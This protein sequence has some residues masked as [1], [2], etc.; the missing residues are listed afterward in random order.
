MSYSWDPRTQ[1]DPSECTATLGGLRTCAAWKQLPATAPS[2]RPLHFNWEQGR[3]LSAY[4]LV[5]VTGR[6]AC[7][8]SCCRPLS[9]AMHWHNNVRLMFRPC[10]PPMQAVR[11]TAFGTRLFW[12]LSVTRQKTTCL[13]LG[14]KFWCQWSRPL[15]G[16]Q[17]DLGAAT[18]RGLR[19]CRSAA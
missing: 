10:C 12:R 5:Y 11:R 8:Q 1:E 15:P 13:N 4:Q 19:L 17:P 18:P 14:L 16:S 3:A 2:R 6:W 7:P 9:G